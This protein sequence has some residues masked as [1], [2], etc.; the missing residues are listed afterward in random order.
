MRRYDLTASQSLDFT[1]TFHFLLFLFLF[2]QHY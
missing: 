2:Q 1:T